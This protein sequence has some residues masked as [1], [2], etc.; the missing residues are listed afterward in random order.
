MKDGSFIKISLEAT[1]ASDSQHDN[2][3]PF[4][5]LRGILQ[6][7]M[8]IFKEIEFVVRCACDLILVSVFDFHML[9]SSVGMEGMAALRRESMDSSI[10][11]IG[12]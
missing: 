4:D 7:K 8:A 11:K 3:Y 1:P 10:L 2:D 5:G 12:Y 6:T 9:A